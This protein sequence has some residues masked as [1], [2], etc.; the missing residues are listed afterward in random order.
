MACVRPEREACP[1]CGCRGAFHIHGYYNRYL[2]EP[3][4][5]SQVCHQVRV[6]RL[7]CGNCGHTHAVLPDIVIPYRSHSLPFILRVIGVYLRRPQNVESICSRFLISIPTLYEW[8]RTFRLHKQEWL[9]VLADSEETASHFLAWLFFTTPFSGFAADFYV[10]TF[11]SFLQ[12]HE[13]PANC[14][15]PP[16]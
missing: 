12:A 4:G 8:L 11:L 5:Q 15:H 16:R 13:N 6:T 7:I 14:C 9:G 10:K 3:K 2:I 1:T